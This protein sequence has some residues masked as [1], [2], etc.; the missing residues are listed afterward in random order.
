[1]SISCHIFTEWWILRK[2]VPSISVHIPCHIFLVL[3]F[4]YCPTILLLFHFIPD[5]L[6][7]QQFLVPQIFSVVL[8]ITSFKTLVT[9]PDKMS[10]VFLMTS[11]ISMC[12]VPTVLQVQGTV[13]TV[14]AVARTCHS[15][16]ECTDT[17]I[18]RTTY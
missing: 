18:D 7:T 17:C 5:G 6:W 13:W 3:I 10:C 8:P 14:L 15:H 16:T 2:Y 1:M 11:S 4:H 12:P 9:C